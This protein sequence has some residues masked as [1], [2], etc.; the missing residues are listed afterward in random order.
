VFEGALAN[1][2]IA[3]SPQPTQAAGHVCSPLGRGHPAAA[4]ADDAGGVGSPSSCPPQVQVDAD[5]AL[6]TDARSVASL[7]MTRAPGLAISFS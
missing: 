3:Q 1:D 2:L 5:N 7:P 6:E 4:L